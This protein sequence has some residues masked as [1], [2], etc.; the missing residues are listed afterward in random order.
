MT[1][2]SGDRA[3]FMSPTTSKTEINNTKLRLMPR[4]NLFGEEGRE[5]LG[6]PLVLACQFLVTLREGLCKGKEN[7]QK[8]NKGEGE[9]GGRE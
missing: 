2:R 9:N 3:T 7:K 4:N 1:L 5:G 6:A 8:R